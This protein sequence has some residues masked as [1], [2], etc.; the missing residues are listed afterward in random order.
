MQLGNDVGSEE[1]DQCGADVTAPVLEILCLDPSD[2]VADMLCGI[3][4]EQRLRPDAIR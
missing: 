1:L 3:D 2:G 4:S